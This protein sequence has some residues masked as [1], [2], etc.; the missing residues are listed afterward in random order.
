MDDV[1]RVTEILTLSRDDNCSS[2]SIVVRAGSYDLLAG[3][4]STSLEITRRTE[5]AWVSC[6]Y[7]DCK[8]EVGAR[9]AL[10]DYKESIASTRVW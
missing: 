10:C 7:A 2:C 9:K 6:G 5:D 3:Y 4:S 8:Q 1:R